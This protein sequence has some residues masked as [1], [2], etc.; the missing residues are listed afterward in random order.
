MM[1]CKIAE[2]YIQEIKAEIVMQPW[3]MSITFI[4]V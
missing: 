4:K 1:L 3:K 2:K